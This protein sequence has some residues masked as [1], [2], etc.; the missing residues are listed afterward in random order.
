MML[1]E[2]QVSARYGIQVVFGGFNNLGV[3]DDS[4]VIRVH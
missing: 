4:S 3:H 2:R 1:R